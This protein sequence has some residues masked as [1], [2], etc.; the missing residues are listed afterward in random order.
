[1]DFFY[2][3]EV[4]FNIEEGVFKNGLNYEFLFKLIFWENIVIDELELVFLM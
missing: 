3:D 2:I 1:M 4:E